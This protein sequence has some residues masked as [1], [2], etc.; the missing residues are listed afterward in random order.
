MPPAIRYDERMSTS[1]RLMWNNERDPMLRSTILARLPRA[2]AVDLFGSMLK[3][4]DVVTS[5]V[6]GPPFPV[7][8]SGALVERMIGC[9]PLSGAPST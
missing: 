9:G 5:T 3:A 2:F 7:F 1:D 8:A 6:P 4:I